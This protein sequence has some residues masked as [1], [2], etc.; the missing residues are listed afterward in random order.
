MSLSDKMRLLCILDKN[1]LFL[2]ARRPS[3]PYSRRMGRRVAF[4]LASI[5]EGTSVRMWRRLLS[6]FDRERDAVFVLP[7]GRLGFQAGDEYLRNDIYPLVTARSFDGLVAWA[8]TLGGQVS[9]DEVRRF[10]KGYEA[11]PTVTIGLKVAPE[12]PVVDFDAYRGFHALVCH[13]VK[14]HRKK[15]IVFLRGPENHSSSQER[16]QAYQDALAECGIA[17]DMDLVSSPFPWGDG[18]GALEEIMT[19]RGLVPSLDFDAMVCASDLMM[20]SAVRHLEELGVNIP[21]SVAVGGFN[22]SE[23]NKLLRVPPTTVRMPVEAMMDQALRNMNILMEGGSVEYSRLE[24][25]LVVRRSCG[26]SDSFG[27]EDMAKD[28]IEGLDGFLDWAIGYCGGRLERDD[29]EFFSVYALR[30]KNPS[31]R[32][33]DNFLSRFASICSRF[34]ERGGESEDLVEV[35]HWFSVL[36][37]MD[38]AL[39]DFC[40]QNLDRAILE[41]YSR[42]VGQEEYERSIQTGRLNAFKVALLSARSHE[43]LSQTI[44]RDLPSLGFRQC[45]IVLARETGWRL[46]AGYTPLTG[47]VQAEDFSKDCI[48]PPRYDELTCRGAFVVEPMIQDRECV[49]HVILEVDQTHD[50]QMVEDVVASIASALKGVRLLEEAR[51]AKDR[52]EEA[53]KAEKAF[54][55]NLSEELRE[56]LSSIRNVLSLVVDSPAREQVAG[57]VMKAEHLL[58]LVLTEKGEVEIECRIVDSQALLSGFASSRDWASVS[59]PDRLPA[60]STDPEKLVQ[61]LE[62]LHNLAIEAGEGEKASFQAVATPNFLSLS[63]SMDK[64]RPSLMAGSPS[65]QLAEETVVLLSGSFH[66]KEHAVLVTLPWPS[67]SGQTKAPSYG[68]ILFLAARQGDEVPQC[69]S[70]FSQLIVMEEGALVDGFNLP[71]D[72]TQIAYDAAAD[73]SGDSTALK[74]L[75]NHQAT[76]DLP[77]LCFGLTSCGADLWTSLSVQGGSRPKGSADILVIGNLPKELEGLDAFGHKLS[78][79]NVDSLVS[80]MRSA[81]ALI[82]LDRIDVADLERLRHNSLSAS[83]PILI[84]KDVFTKDEVE[85]ILSLPSLLICNSSICASQ[86]FLSRLIGI[87]AGRQILPPLTGALVKKAIVYLNQKATSQISRWQIADSVNIS[88]D[89]L[90][91]IFKKDM[92]ISP[93]DYL[94]RYRIQLAGELLRTSGKTINE[95]AGEVGFQDQAYFCRVF[96][97]IVGVAPGKMRR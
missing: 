2:L 51:E 26:C 74:L 28:R 25:S 82:I 24:S 13:L 45:Y 49:G 50:E 4:I 87:F 61:A 11:L 55:A 90:T 73:H 66:Y 80:S 3:P 71:G 83:T 68:N 46:I 33:R 96:K 86:E 14:V 44:A 94:N 6:S 22:D 56:P 47:L 91:R 43:A 64:W 36:L 93:W 38:P 37:P 15:R 9:V 77:F 40:R 58:D 85:P 17:L 95:I 12:V 30:L 75:R 8:S 18:R 39:A 79:D 88:E 59:I 16:Y 20:F 48:L 41:N 89:Y 67:L 27:G 62:I 65:L 7:G 72:L 19:T 34:F 21:H 42:Q 52:A 23:T 97:K 57:A 78:F 53:E 32:E 70:Q 63:I 31:R 76:R 5:H 69:L 1:D 60:L 35:F 92:G 29:L 81:P 10:I 84:V 54:Y